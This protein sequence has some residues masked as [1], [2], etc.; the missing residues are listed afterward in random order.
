[1]VYN[2]GEDSTALQRVQLGVLMH[3]W[4]RLAHTLAVVDL[5][6]THISPSLPPKMR[7][8]LQKLQCDIY[9]ARNQVRALSVA[10]GAW[11]Q[12]ARLFA[13]NA[14]IFAKEIASITVVHGDA[15]MSLAEYHGLRWRRRSIIGTIV[16]WWLPPRPILPLVRLPEDRTKKTKWMLGLVAKLL[17]RC[18]PWS[19]G[20]AEHEVRIK[21]ENLER[22]ILT[23]SRRNSYVPLDCPTHE[24]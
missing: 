21:Q 24:S 8:A 10:G 18:L 7:T 2:G 17:R 4:A 19:L 9:I 13:Y 11:D 3:Y 22:S 6:N 20:G 15:V 16:A 5:E 14:E 23:A 12:S 1:M